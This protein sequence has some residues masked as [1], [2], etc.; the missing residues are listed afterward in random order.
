M[1][2]MDNQAVWLAAKGDHGSVG[3]APLKQPGPDQLLIRNR[4]V[5]MNPVDCE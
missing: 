1:T 5:A 3:P 4:A 2:T